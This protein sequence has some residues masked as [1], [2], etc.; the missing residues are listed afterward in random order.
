MLYAG[1]RV[2]ETYAI[3]LNDIEIYHWSGI[4]RIRKGKNAKERDVPLPKPARDV[5]TD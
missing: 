1:P 2:E 5:L 4:M 3:N